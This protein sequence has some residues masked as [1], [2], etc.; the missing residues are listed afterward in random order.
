MGK[1]LLQLTK[2]SIKRR[3]R[4]IWRSCMATF[5]A[6]FFITGVLLFQ[7]NMYQWQM[8]SNME[9]FGDWF[10]MD[11]ASAEPSEY[12]TNHPYIEGYSQA[13]YIMQVYQEPFGESITYMG[14]MS[15]D[16]IEKSHIAAELG[17]MP[18]TKGEIAMD[19]DTLGEFGYEAKIGQTVTLYYQDGTQKVP[20]QYKLVGVLRNY[21]SSW[22]AGEQLPGVI[23][24]KEEAE[25]FDEVTRHVYIYSMDDAVRT[26][27]F[28]LIYDNMKE[29]YGKP[30]IYNDNVYDYK[31]WGL[32]LIYNY[33]YILV[34]AIGITALTYQIIIYRTSRQQ[35]NNKLRNMGATKGQINLITYMENLLIII[36][37]GLLGIV[38][39][40]LAGKVICN[41]I[42]QKMQVYFYRLNVQVF[43]KAVISIVVA[44]IVEEIVSIIYTKCK[45]RIKKPGKKHR[46]QS[47]NIRTPKIKL[48]KSNFDYVVHHRFMK[49]NGVVPNIAVRIFSLANCVVILF[50]IIN[51]Y[52]AYRANGENEATPDVIGYK[53]E[54]DSYYYRYPMF[55]KSPYSNLSAS[56][57]NWIYLK[58]KA[59]GDYLEEFNAYFKGDNFSQPEKISYTA[60]KIKDS[61]YMKNGNTNLTKGY[62]QSFIDNLKT[63]NGIESVEYS[64]FETQRMWSWDGMDFE[65]M[66]ID[67][68]AKEGKVSVAEYGDRYWYATNYVSATKKIYDKLAKYVDR[69]YFDFDTFVR[70]EQVVLFV[71]D[72]P[73]GEYEDTIAVGD[74]IKYHYYDVP[75]YFS[76]N[77]NQDEVFSYADG[78]ERIAT[79]KLYSKEDAE[80][81]H[82]AIYSENMY[83]DRYLTDEELLDDW[84]QLNFE[85]CV[86]PT[87]AGVIKLT[88]EIKAEFKDL[89]VDYGYYTAIA[90]VRMAETACENQNKLMA[91]IL[92]V[93]ELPTE[94]KCEP[95]YNQISIY[96]DLSSSYSATANIVKVYFKEADVRY[97]SNT[98]QKETLRTKTIS[99]MLQYG[100]T[101]LAAMLIN[102]LIIAIVIRN[103]IVAR[104]QKLRTLVRLGLDKARLCR[105]CMIEGVRESVWCIFT[106]PFVMVIEY[107]IYR[108]AIGGLE[109]QNSGYDI[110]QPPKIVTGLRK[111]W[112]KL[113]L[114]SAETYASA[115]VVVIILLIVLITPMA[116]A[117]H[118]KG[119]EENVDTD[120]VI[121]E[122]E[123]E[124][125]NNTI[126]EVETET[127][128]VVVM[129]PPS[130][131]K[132][133]NEKTKLWVITVEKF[134]L[135]AGVT[136]VSKGSNYDPI[137]YSWGTWDETLNQAVVENKGGTKENIS[138]Y[139]YMV[140]I[141]MY[142]G[143]SIAKARDIEAEYKRL[144]A[145]T[146]LNIHIGYKENSQQKYYLFGEL[147]LAEL[148]EFPANSEY[149]Y[150]IRII[151]EGHDK[152]YDKTDVTGLVKYEEEEDI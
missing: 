106:M 103:R 145:Q 54:T 108:K 120:Y 94:A 50:C 52:T 28:R 116:S 12:L 17:R 93:K 100:V 138:K 115:G 105:I 29:S 24:T 36:P 41:L 9:R 70:G 21:T 147:T 148:R 13:S 123:V 48:N 146:D 16:F 104:R 8:A 78:F 98:E 112:H 37:F 65:K 150:N 56:A 82:G 121:E 81:W 126:A 47:I 89:L 61:M 32:P 144:K 53:P 60:F 133:Y 135:E 64:Y 68:L 67:L 23:V 130:W 4:E 113:S 26:D 1:Q 14:Y 20:K 79:G 97:I 101:M 42:E 59:Y 143:F 152:I 27:D 140:E 117:K 109:L 127:R 99:A 30:L 84:R 34:M 57:D 90:S 91:D 75:L 33:M 63:V 58:D 5:L 122:T 87:V 141:D 25:N 132:T 31:P 71:D 40:G 134:E 72:N 62:R 45:E 55:I 69:E 35:Y 95:V 22:P 80:A 85:A 107:V 83:S 39:A 76:D 128:K 136:Y 111:T 119:K 19:Y 131:V 43:V 88:D 96:Y 2:K 11:V 51:M 44:I 66:G 118:M 86:E 6:I 151:Q 38:C 73:Y 7:E 15:D 149:T 124:S 3:W 114:I 142:K 92:E 102:V 10:V 74:K 77:G 137:V 46:K 110:L 129:P 49:S 139:S 125:E 18:G